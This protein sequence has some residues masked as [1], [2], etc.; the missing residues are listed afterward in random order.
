MTGWLAVLGMECVRCR[1]RPAKATHS[2]RLW[3]N[4]IKQSFVANPKT[5]TYSKLA[6]HN[7]MRHLPTGELILLIIHDHPQ[8]TLVV[9]RRELH[10]IQTEVN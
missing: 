5:V 4:I 1:R 8:R 6:Q 3:Y 10:L 9:I 2:R 7:D